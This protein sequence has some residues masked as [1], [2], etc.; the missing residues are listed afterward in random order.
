MNPLFDDRVQELVMHDP[1]LASELP[2][3]S[4]DRVY[5]L[6]ATKNFEQIL[7]SRASIDRGMQ[8][9]GDLVRSSPF[10]EGIASLLF[11]FLILEA[12]SGRSS[13]N[14]NDIFNQT[15]FPIQT[16]LKLQEHLRAQVQENEAGPS[17]LVWYFAYKGDSWRVYGCYS[18]QEEPARYVSFPSSNIQMTDTLL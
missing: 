6:Q 10:K 18:T 12:K 11:P 9:V 14:F 7:F 16:L 17:P 4:P 8:T 5:G 3:K 15:A 13:Y 2:K 1:L